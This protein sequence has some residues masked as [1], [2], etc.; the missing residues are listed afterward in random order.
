MI[1]IYTPRNINLK[2]I[3][4]HD[5]YWKSSKLKEM[6]AFARSIDFRNEET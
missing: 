4:S 1:S 2:N 3:Q 6:I 5:L